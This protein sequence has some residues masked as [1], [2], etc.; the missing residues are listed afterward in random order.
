MSR[1]P[2]VEENEYEK[3]FKLAPPEAFMETLEDVEWNC[4][5]QEAWKEAVGSSAF[6]Q[7]TTRRE[8]LAFLFDNLSNP[9]LPLEERFTHSQIASMF[10]ISRQAAEEQVKKH[11]N[12]VY[13]PHRPGLFNEKEINDLKTFL[14]SGFDSRQWAT[15]SE[16]SQFI[17]ISFG[18][19][20]KRNSITVFLRKQ[21]KNIGRFIDATPIE[22]NRFAVNPAEI[23]SYYDNLRTLLVLIDYRFCFNID[24]TGEDE[25][26]DTRDVKVFVP[27]DFA[28]P[29]ATIPVSRTKKRFTIEHCIC[30]DGTYF[31]LYI[32]VPRKTFQKDFYKIYSPDRIQLR[33]QPKGF[34][35]LPIF[36]DYFF[37]H[38]LHHLDLKR[39]NL[40]YQG[41][42]L[43]IMDNLL[44]H[45]Q[46]V[47]CPKQQSYIFLAPYNLHI[48][49]LVPHSSDQTQPLDL[50]IF[51]NQKR[52]SQDIANISE[53]SAFS[54]LLNKAIQGMEKASTTRAIVSA[55]DS[56]GIVRNIS[57]NGNDDLKISLVVDKSR[58]RGVR[59]YTSI[60]PIPNT[61]SNERIVIPNVHGLH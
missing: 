37:N 54:N 41:P 21:F 50:G 23:D 24:E 60:A 39:K 43:L 26:V 61:W 13:D 3:Y 19:H 9:D 31:P 40:S 27:V 25:Y 30:T 29:K 18:R 11:K 5:Q 20:I 6:K 46:A 8:Q 16:I 14:M 33:T 42:A 22:D 56:A 12:G 17:E 34:M 53:L 1:P 52:Y 55:F 47:G 49:F 4:I 35:N 10:N 44:C 36:Q 7:L 15:Y 51:G 28:L 45:K 38:F 48:L 32:I 2:P 58:C 59:H 57:G